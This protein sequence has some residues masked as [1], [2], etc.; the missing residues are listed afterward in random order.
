LREKK[1][2]QQQ[3][4]RDRHADWIRLQRERDARGLH[5]TKKPFPKHADHVDADALEAQRK[6]QRDAECR[7]AQRHQIEE[8]RK[9]DRERA[10]ATRRLEQ[11]M[12]DASKASFD[13][14]PSRLQTLVQA[15]LEIKFPAYLP[16]STFS[17]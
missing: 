11:Q 16:K 4:E 2:R 15:E 6:R 9:A 10:E 17:T 7:L 5:S 8:R 14:S 13:Q 3:M 12:L 1:E